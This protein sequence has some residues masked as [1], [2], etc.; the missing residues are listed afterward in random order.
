MKYIPDSSKLVDQIIISGSPKLI[1]QSRFS[2]INRQIIIIK[3]GNNRRN[4]V[5]IVFDII[6][7]NSSFG[8][9]ARS[10]RSIV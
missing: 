5:K 1:D 3:S 8:V 10:V 4:E 6:R 7:Q 2:K 9:C